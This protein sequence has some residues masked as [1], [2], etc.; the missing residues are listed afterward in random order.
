M[1]PEMSGGSKDGTYLHESP[2]KERRDQ[3]S[4]SIQ[5]QTGDFSIGTALPV[6]RQQVGSTRT[7]NSQLQEFFTELASVPDLE[8][9]PGSSQD[10]SE[11]RGKATKLE[12]KVFCRVW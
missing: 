2:G 6:V 4:N 9:S 3:Q 8:A 1:V 12:I 7:M 10:V 5:G 11:Q